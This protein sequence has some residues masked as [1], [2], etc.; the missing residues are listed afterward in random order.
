MA[1]L[2]LSFKSTSVLRSMDWNLHTKE[3]SEGLCI[4]F[5]FGFQ[6]RSSWDRDRKASSNWCSSASS[7]GGIQRR[8]RQLPNKGHFVPGFCYWKDSHLRLFN[9]ALILQNPSFEIM[10]A[11]FFVFSDNKTAHGS[12]EFGPQ[13]PACWGPDQSQQIFEQ[14][15]PHS[16][17]MITFRHC[18]FGSYLT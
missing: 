14:R 7:S 15:P 10:E 6:D 9:D 1:K 2:G 11:N 13:T 16:C 8:S 4:I 5:V 17:E 12:A 18:R 3:C